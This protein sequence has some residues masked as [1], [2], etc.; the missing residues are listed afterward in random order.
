MTQEQLESE[1][2]IPVMKMVEKLP[3]IFDWVEFKG[4]TV[5]AGFNFDRSLRA[6]KP[7]FDIFYCATSALNHMVLFT[8]QWDKSKFKPSHLANEWKPSPP[9]LT[10]SK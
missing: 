9:R 7:M 1:I 3:V 8:T 10:I 5:F 6:R 2:P 4:E